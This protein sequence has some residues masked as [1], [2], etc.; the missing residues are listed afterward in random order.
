MLKLI[1]SVPFANNN[2]YECMVLK[3]PDF[4]MRGMQSSS[5]IGTAVKASHQLKSTFDFLS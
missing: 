2:L 3:F 4:D 1:F 5:I